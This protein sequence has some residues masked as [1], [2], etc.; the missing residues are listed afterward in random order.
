MVQLVLFWG[1]FDSF[2]LVEKSWKAMGEPLYFLVKFYAFKIH[3]KFGLNPGI[4]L[5]CSDNQFV[6]W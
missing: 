4:I 3:V 2:K 5:V 1:H 6:Q